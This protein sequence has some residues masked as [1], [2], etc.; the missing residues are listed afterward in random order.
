MARRHSSSARSSTSPV[1]NRFGL[2]ETEWVVVMRTVAGPLKGSA[3]GVSPTRA[4][5]RQMAGCGS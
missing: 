3:A 4:V 2:P 5:M 1:P